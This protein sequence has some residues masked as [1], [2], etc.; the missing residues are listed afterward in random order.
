[1][2]NPFLHW[3][4]IYRRTSSCPELNNCIQI[5][6]EKINSIINKLRENTANDSTKSNFMKILLE[7]ELVFSSN[8]HLQDQVNTFLFAVSF[9]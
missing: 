4:W 9:D 6:H 5:I 2:I 1:M 8:T 3:D 7:N